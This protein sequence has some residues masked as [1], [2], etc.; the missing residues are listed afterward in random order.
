M[1]LQNSQFLCLRLYPSDKRM[2]STS[3][4]IG[5]IKCL[6]PHTGTNC[7][8]QGGNIIFGRLG[9]VIYFT[10]AFLKIILVN[11]LSLLNL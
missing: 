9:L 3:Y 4:E 11:S 8:R 6:L 1:W 7:T 10:K 2:S 5:S